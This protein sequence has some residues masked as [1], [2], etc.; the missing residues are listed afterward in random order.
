MTKRQFIMLAWLM[1]PGMLWAQDPLPSYYPEDLPRTGP[2]ERLDLG[3][4]VVVV[5]DTLY[6]LARYVPVHTPRLEMADLGDLAEG[7]EIAFNHER[8]VQGSSVITEIWKLPKGH[9]EKSEE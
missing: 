4:R 2:L 7:D 6:R 1:L 9:R 3:E 5:N 8:K